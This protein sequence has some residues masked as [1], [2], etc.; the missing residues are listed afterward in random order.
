[1]HSRS[2]LVNHVAVSPCEWLDPHKMYCVAEVYDL[3]AIYIGPYQGDCT[4]ISLSNQVWSTGPVFAVPSSTA[5]LSFPT[6]SLSSSSGLFPFD[7]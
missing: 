5:A 7:L 2:A 6:L 3:M 1:M 4:H